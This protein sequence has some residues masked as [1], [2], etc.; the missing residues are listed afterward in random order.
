MA[1][2]SFYTS[3][4]SHSELAASEVPPGHLQTGEVAVEGDARVGSERD[5]V[6]V[7]LAPLELLLQVRAH[8]VDGS[9]LRASRLLSSGEAST[10]RGKFG[11]SRYSL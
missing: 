3:F 6:V 7:P 4:G 1:W 8:L 2:I 11:D 9:A 10:A 5:Q